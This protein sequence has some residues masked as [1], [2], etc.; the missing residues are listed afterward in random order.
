[1][2]V[3]AMVAVNLHDADEAQRERFDAQMDSQDWI[4]V[5]KLRATWAGNFP[6]AELSAA[7]VLH[8]NAVDTVT[9]AARAAG[10]SRF[11]AAVHVGPRIPVLFNG[12]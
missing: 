4:K 9:H 8:Q 2:A 1:M 6:N 10:I 7:E 12:P 3:T 5:P 11:D